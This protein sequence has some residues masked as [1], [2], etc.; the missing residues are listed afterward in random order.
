MAVTL[1]GGV[2]TPV[3]N[4]EW[5][6]RR[7]L[8]GT[9]S[10]LPTSTDFRL[11]DGFWRRVV[12]YQRIGTEIV[13]RDY[14][15]GDGKT[16]RF[17]DGEFGAI[18]AEGT[19]FQA[20]YRLGLGADD[21]VTAGTLT[22]CALP[23]VQSVTNPVP[24]TG[25]ADPETPQQ[26]RQLAPEAFRALTFRAVRPEDYAEALDRLDWVQRAGA[27]FRWTGSWLTAFASPD[28]RGAFAVS[29][30]ER[31]EAFGQ[32]DRFRQ[33]GRP[34][35]M[36]DPVYANLDLQI[37]VCVGASAYRG[38]VEERVLEA[39]FGKKGIR[40]KAGF[41]SPDN[42]T[43]GSPLERSQLE[44]VIQDVAGVRAVEKIFFRRRGWFDWR[45]FSELTF[46][47]APNE[48][49]RVA[50]DPMFPDRGSVKLVMDGGA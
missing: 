24:S 23:I 33:A 22:Q 18:P 37:T 30:V 46:S 3:P 40:P 43:F 6:W 4:G 29:A 17:G 39:R 12:G 49:I 20:M 19:I 41:F 38:E 50:N 31:S 8:L 11:D 15:S 1:V 27:E 44:A 26:I 16:I 48:L 45:E 14:A 25:A 35:Y 13:H 7:E 32:L 36:L 47:V 34:A 28:P 42:F 2:W 9:N 21:N 5:T 10:S